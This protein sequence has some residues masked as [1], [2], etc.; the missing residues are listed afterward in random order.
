MAIIFVS[1]INDQSKIGVTLDDNGGLIRLVDGN[2]SVH[3]RI[4][5]KK[6]VSAYY[7]LFGKGVKQMGVD[8]PKQPSMVFN[9]ISDPDTHRG[10]LERCVEF[11]SQLESYVVNH[12]EKIMQ[13]GRDRVSGNLQGIPGVIMPK[14]VRFRPLSPDEIFEQAEK[15]GID[16]PFIVRIAGYHHGKSTELVT[17]RDDYSAM[18]KYPLDGRD[19]YLTEYVDCSDDSGMHCKQRL[20]VIDGEPVLRHSMYN[21]RW[22]IHSESLGYMLERESWDDIHARDS[23]FESEVLPT[24]LPAIEEIT[25]RLQLEFYGIDCYVRPD[26]EM[27]IF[28]AN[29]N[30]N[31]LYNPYPQRNERMA[32]INRKIYGLLTKYSGEAVI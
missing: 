8:L 16:F 15:E 13:T 21:E 4:P 9:Q 1:G 22:D 27:V 11:C 7:T 30:M 28:E 18:H 31:P 17:S 10:S 14:T 24:L 19:F 6:G 25:K 23:Q 32:M 2:C 29:A 12:P 5:M 3:G 20:L 26:G